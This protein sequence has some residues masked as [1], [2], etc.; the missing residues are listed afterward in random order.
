MDRFVIA[1]RKMI[2]SLVFKNVKAMY[3]AFYKWLNY[4]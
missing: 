3:F 4:F 1:L 2:F